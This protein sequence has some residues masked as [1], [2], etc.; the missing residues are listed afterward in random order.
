[1]G[2]TTSFIRRHVGAAVA[3]GV[4]VVALAGGGIA[5]AATSSGSS[6]PAKASPPPASAPASSGTHGSKAK[7]KH[8]G[9]RGTVTAVSGGA[10]TVK[11]A[12]GVSMT[13]TVTPQTTFGTKKAPSSATSFPVGS[14]VRVSGQQNGTSITATRITA[15]KAASGSTTGGSTPSTTTAS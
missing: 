8:P 15:P 1:M 12:K 4:A 13:V 14:T 10:W 9:V 6:A 7:A 5:Y 3:S 2:Q 11:T